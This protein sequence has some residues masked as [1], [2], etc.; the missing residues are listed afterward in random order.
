MVDRFKTTISDHNFT[1][2]KLMT[3]ALKDRLIFKLSS[4]SMVKT[5]TE[6]SAPHY[7]P[8]LPLLRWKEAENL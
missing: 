7:S 8:S 1:N 2:Q 3:I 5:K 6:A 4:K